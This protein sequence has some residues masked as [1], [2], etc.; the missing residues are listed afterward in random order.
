[1]QLKTLTRSQAPTSIDPIQFL[2]A[3]GG[4]TLIRL[5]GK[6]TS[7]TRAFSTLLHGNEPSGLQAIINYLKS[8]QTP[9]VNIEIIIASVQAALAKPYLSHRTLPGK[10]DLNRCFQPPFESEEDRL[11]EEILQSLEASMPECLIDMHNTSGSGPSFAVAIANDADHLA[12]TSLWTNDLI[13]TDLRLGAVME[14]SEA[15]IP[16]VTIECG[17]SDDRTSLII[18]QEGLQRYFQNENV[19]AQSGTQYGVTSYRNPIRMELRSGCS[20][21]YKD[22]SPN[23][24]NLIENDDFYRN[25]VHDVTMAQ[26]ADRLNYGSLPAGEPI[27]WLGAQGIDVLTAKDY[28]GI[29]KLPEHFS[30][31]YRKG[32][33]EGQCLIAKHPLKLFMVTTNA[34]IGQED[35]LFYFIDC[36][37]Q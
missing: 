20:L 23:Q 25:L 3:L 26:D 18:A 29:E 36:A 32:A 28:R 31:A 6:D 24:Q 5:E 34:R 8:G 16:T 19:L 37:N 30:V 7:R 22:I 4:P 17:G 1:M 12:L 14:L 27:L 9:A 10:P 15:S 21:I 35:C 33:K 11:A 13:V 2:H